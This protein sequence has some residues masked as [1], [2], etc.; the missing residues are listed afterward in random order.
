MDFLKIIIIGTIAEAV[1]I[2]IFYAKNKFSL[3]TR[4][5]MAFYPIIMPIAIGCFAM[6]KFGFSSPLAWGLILFAGVFEIVL[7]SILFEKKIITPIKSVTTAMEEINSGELE[8]DITP[9]NN[10]DEIG[11]L[12]TAVFNLQAN[13]KSK[14]GVIDQISRGNISGTNINSSASD[15]LSKSILLLQSTFQDL[16]NETSKMIDAARS[17]QL[18]A[19]ADSSK[20]SGDFARLIQGLNENTETLMAPITEALQVL[21]QLA[22]RDLSVKM[23]GEYHGDYARIKNALNR[24]VSNLDDGMQKVT[25]SAEQVATASDQ[26]SSGSQSLSQAS[27]EQASSLEEITSSL[28]EIASMIKQTTANA[29]EARGISEGAQSTTAE[30]MDSMQRLSSVMEQIK[31]SSGETAK[32]VKTIDDIAFQ[33]NLLALNA[34]VEAARA[35]EAGKGFAVVAEEV[36]NLAMRSAEAAKNTTTLIEEAVSNA[37]NGVTVNSE[38]VQKLSAINDQVRKVN[39][40]MSEIAAASQQ[41]NDGINQLNAAVDQL[42]Q[43]TQQNAANSQESASTAHELLSHANDLREMASQFK[44]STR[45]SSSGYIHK[46][47]PMSAPSKNYSSQSTA[48]RTVNFDM[49]SIRNTVSS[50][51]PESIIPFDDDDGDDD[52]ILSEF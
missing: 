12:S 36:R 48:A 26:I 45:I 18:H 8:T 25:N 17:G 32:I 52:A 42:N 21:E 51:S 44:L 16:I 38:V 41:Q 27:S 37:E 40:V 1:K 4:I 46:S 31:N 19:R 6:G 35:G 3:I 20:F 14:V 33:T 47:A 50:S 10:D 43:L 24:A 15:A 7:T 2:A 23:D 49:E 28:K 9:S 39:D 13:L 34:A 30:G 29:K 22:D 11:R 5:N